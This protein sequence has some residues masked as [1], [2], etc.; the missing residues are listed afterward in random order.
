M[1]RAVAA[2]VAGAVVLSAFVAVPVLIVRVATRRSPFAQTRGVPRE[3]RTTMAIAAVLLV[4]GIGCLG[5]P[6]RARGPQGRLT[7]GPAASVLTGGSGPPWDLPRSVPPFSEVEERATREQLACLRGAGPWVALGGALLAAAGLV[8]LMSW[9]R[10][11]RTIVALQA[12]PPPAAPA[13]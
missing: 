8:A 3:V 1:I 13:A 9:F 11:A 10:A 7:C 5:A 4:A 2:F 6:V 12:A